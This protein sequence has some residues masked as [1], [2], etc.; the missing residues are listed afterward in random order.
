MDVFP[1]TIAAKAWAGEIEKGISLFIHK[2]VGG[3]LELLNLHFVSYLLQSGVQVGMRCDKELMPVVDRVF[4]SIKLYENVMDAVDKYDYEVYE[5]DIALY[6]KD[7]DEPGWNAFRIN[8]DNIYVEKW[9]AKL[10]DDS[11]VCVCP[12]ID[13][14]IEQSRTLVVDDFEFDSETVNK[15]STLVIMTTEKLS[16]DNLGDIKNRYTGNSIYSVALSEINFEDVLAIL[17][18]SERV[19]AA[20]NRYFGLSLALGKDTVLL[21]SGVV[22][23]T[24]LL[25]TFYSSLL[26]KKIN[27]FSDCVALR[28]VCVVESET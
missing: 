24:R 8:P 4:P 16:E 10:K 14:G 18:M 23:T 11:F 12:D 15:Y 9:G 6:Q 19:Y 3:L 17:F 7:R 13:D 26:T 21:E 22:K 5:A 28:K 1:E 2:E 20:R 27:D 25:R